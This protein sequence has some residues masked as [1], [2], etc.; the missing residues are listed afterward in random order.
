MSVV[1]SRTKN[2]VYFYQ[3][4]RVSDFFDSFNLVLN[5]NFCGLYSRVNISVINDSVVELGFNLWLNGI[6]RNR[7]RVDSDLNQLIGFFGQKK[8]VG[9]HTANKLGKFFFDKAECFKGI[10]SCQSV[11]R[12]CDSNDRKLRAAFQSTADIFTCFLRLDYGARDSRPV[13]AL[14]DFSV[15]KAALDVA[16]RRDRQVNPP[17]V[18]LVRPEAG[19]LPVNSLF[20]QCHTVPLEIWR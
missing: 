18:M 4:S 10:G 19:M 11:S 15:T 14:V 7:E 5:E 2:S 8:S 16:A 17:L 3:H 13:F 12:A 6:Y 1:D 9:A 20:V